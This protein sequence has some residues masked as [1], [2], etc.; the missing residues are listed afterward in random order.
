MCNEC[1]RISLPGGS[2]LITVVSYHIDAKLST[3]NTNVTLFD[4]VQFRTFRTK[5]F[6]PKQYKWICKL[7]IFIYSVYHYDSPLLVCIVNFDD[8]GRVSQNSIPLILSLGTFATA[9]VPF[10]PVFPKHLGN[11]AI[12]FFV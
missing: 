1:F 7:F 4:N 10:R 5:Q 3:K 9:D 2:Y 11:L 6:P 12:K 8:R